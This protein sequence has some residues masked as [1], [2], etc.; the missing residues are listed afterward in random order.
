KFGMRESPQPRSSMVG[1]QPQPASC[2]VPS[3]FPPA[4]GHPRR[5]RLKRVVAPAVRVA[6]LAAIMANKGRRG[7]GGGRLLNE[8][9]L[10]IPIYLLPGPKCLGSAFSSRTG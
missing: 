5:D 1:S 4:C 3:F 8:F 2:A 7:E 9:R 10:N 6:K